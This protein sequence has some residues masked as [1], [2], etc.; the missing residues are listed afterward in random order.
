MASTDKNTSKNIVNARKRKPKDVDTEEVCITKRSKT[1]EKEFVFKKN[2]ADESE[3]SEIISRYLQKEEVEHYK[4]INLLMNEFNCSSHD[5]MIYCREYEKSQIQAYIDENLKED[6]SGLMYVCGHPGTGKSSIIRV[7]LKELEEKMKANDEFSNSIAI[8]NY[9]GM[10]FKKLYDFS[11]ELIKDIR[12][13]FYNKKSKN[14]EAKLKQTDDVLDLGSRIQK[15]F[16]ETRNVHKLVIIDEVDNLSMTESAKNFVA[17]LHSIL[18]SDTNTTII[19]IANSVDLLSKVSQYSNK[20]GELV[21]KKWI[22][23]PYSERDIT[24]I[25]NKKIIRFNLKNKCETDYIDKKAL[26][27]ASK[28]V[29]KI[30]G[31]IRVAFDLIKSAMILV[32]LKY[33]EEAVRKKKELEGSSEDETLQEEAKNENIDYGNITPSKPFKIILEDP[34]ID[35]KM[36]HYLTT[37]KFGLKS[38]EIIK[39]LPSQLVILLKTI[40]REFDEK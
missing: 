37:T 31:D 17:F 13:K 34:K 22:F 16:I 23:G 15:Y 6:K 26:E 1:H 20:E 35:F 5:M 36:I 18:K 3:E 30:S 9:N 28:K 40:V 38:M 10:I 8:F 27:F 12:I 33:R 19:G 7:I 14:I 21:E 24:K 2:D 4:K 11:T 32:V 39:K 25:I 29:A